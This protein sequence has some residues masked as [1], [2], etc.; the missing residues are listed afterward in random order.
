MAAVLPWEYRELAKSVHY[1]AMSREF[2]EFAVERATAIGRAAAERV[3]AACGPVNGSTEL[4]NAIKASGAQVSI[5]EAA[6]ASD[7]LAEYDERQRLITCYA[8][9]IDRCE[10]A[11]P[12]GRH[13]PLRLLCLAHEL[14]HHLEAV[15][16]GK[17]SEQVK[18]PQKI[19]GFVFRRPVEAAREI[20]AHAFVMRLLRLAGP[21]AAIIDFPPSENLSGR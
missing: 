9:T 20:A 17:V 8:K 1:P 5:D 21:P 18:F 3:L 4:L 12:A 7:R 13:P 6:A 10:A 11:M 16:I 19:C 15:E 14:F 2:R